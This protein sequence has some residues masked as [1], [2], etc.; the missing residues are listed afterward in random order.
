MRRNRNAVIIFLKFPEPGTVKS[1]LTTGISPQ[2]ASSVYEKLLRR[3]LGVVAEFKRARPETDIYLFFSPAEKVVQVRNSFPGP[4]SFLPQGGSHL[5]ERMARAIE[6]VMSEGSCHV[7]LTGTDIADLQPEDY[8]DAFD[9]LNAGY[10]ALGPARDGGYYLI[11][12][13]RPCRDAFLLESWGG[14][15]VFAQTTARLERAGFPVR[16]LQTRQDVDRPED[17]AHLLAKHLFQA[18]LSVIV[19]TI[20]KLDGLAP[21]IRLL[22]DQLWPGD[23]IVIV[24]GICGGPPPDSI[25]IGERVRCVS[26]PVGRGRQLN[27]GVQAARGDMF[28]FLHDDCLLPPNFAYLVR[29]VLESPRQALGC[30]LLSFSPSSAS[31]DLIAAWANLRTRLFHLP[32]GDQGLFCTRGTFLAAG[33][34]H[35]E[36][37][38]EDVDFVRHCLRFA[39]LKLIPHK[40]A[41]SSERYLSRGILRTSFRN[42]L[43]MC[44]HSMG[45]DDRTL[46]SLYYGTHMKRHVDFGVQNQL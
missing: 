37:L 4:W 10:A 23:E 7:V 42:H 21:L 8:C 40:I 34:F 22:D 38:M 43:L 44:L 18:R 9:A 39:G 12:L 36:F 26:S 2:E 20:R 46:Y 24:R 1:R 17:L 31:L 3:T 25:D 33:G 35:R 27:R 32:Y 30:F 15:D 6:R 41:A 14:P 29:S 45:V 11:G 19:P 5:G 16:T 28:L 13:D